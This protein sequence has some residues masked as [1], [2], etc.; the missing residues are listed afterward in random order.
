MGLPAGLP[1]CLPACLQERTI[2]S[3][4]TATWRRRLLLP[5]EAR[6]AGRE[7]SAALIAVSGVGAIFWRPR[8]PAAS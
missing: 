6:Y 8:L 4:S 7:L 5:P 2:Y 3:W 1:A